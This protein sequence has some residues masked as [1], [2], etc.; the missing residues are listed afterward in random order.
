MDR[1]GNIISSAG[2]T[3]EMET[4]FRKWVSTTYGVSK[5]TPKPKCGR[6]TARPH[7][8]KARSK[9]RKKKRK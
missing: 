2:N 8:K 6:G 9:Y 1:L 7:R 3:E 5:N 4:L